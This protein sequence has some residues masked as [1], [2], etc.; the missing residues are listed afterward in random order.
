MSYMLDI[1]EITESAL[2][3]ELIH[4]MEKRAEGKCDYCLQEQGGLSCKMYERH[5]GEVGDIEKLQERLSFLLALAGLKNLGAMMAKLGQ[6][7]R[8]QQQ[9]A[10]DANRT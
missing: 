7:I 3:R 9:A 10:R 4:R 1:D 2:L 8:E 6:A 5:R